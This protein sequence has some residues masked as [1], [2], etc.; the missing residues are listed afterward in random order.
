[1]KLKIRF[2]RLL[3]GVVLLL[4]LYGVYYC[5]ISF[6]VATG[7]GAKVF[8]SAIFV[9]GRNEV[10]I[11]AQEL[12]F[13]PLNFASYKINYDDSSVTC[14]LFGFAT[15]KAIYRKGLGSTIINELSENEIRSQKFRL[16]TQPAIAT[17]TIPWPLGD[18]LNGNFPANIDSVEINNAIADIFKE[19]DTFNPSRTRALIVVYDNQ[20]IAEKYA[21]G[22]TQH[23]RLTGWSMTKSITSAIT[24]IL[25]RK[26]ILDIN[27]PAPVPEWTDTNDVRHKIT[28]KHILQQTTG[29]EFEEIYSKSS[30]ATRMLCQ[31]ADMAAYAASQQLS[32]APG[33]KFHYSS[34]N[35]NILSRIIRQAVGDKDYHALPYE[36]LFYKIG[37]YNTLLEPD[38]SGTF[39]GSS[40]CFATAR[41]WARFGMLYLNNG[42]FDN[43][44]ILPPGWINQSVTASDVVEQGKYGFQWWLNAGNKKDAANRLFPT[45]PADMYF[46]DGFEGQNIFVIPSKKLVVVRLGLTRKRQYGEMEFLEKLI[47]AIR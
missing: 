35:S 25:V 22:F 1:M 27:Q 28:V 12:D 23:T 13:T 26:N 37:M 39:V 30:H 31:T 44:Q 41:D 4:L 40:Y 47:S 29:L 21:P 38:A 18:K 6:P 11:K 36:E 7:Y 8:C 32:H 46:A 33:S 34:G 42:I 20:L 2:T 15:R 19:V 14:S 9:S 5:W 16:P 10:D 17:D 3:L 43:V 45:L 24:G